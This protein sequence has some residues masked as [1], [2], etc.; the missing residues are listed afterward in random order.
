MEKII[1]K[2]TAK[3]IVLKGKPEDGHADVFSYNYEGSA[4]SN[5]GSLFVVG[6]VYPA[7]EDTSYMI[8]LVASLAKREYYSQDNSAHKEA[9]SRT[10][11][12]IN[13]VLQ[14]FFRN[15]D[16]S[17]NIG[18]FAIA[19]DNILI[20]RLGKFKI[21][22]GRD[23]QNIDIL[24]NVSLFEKEHI[25]EKEFSNVISGKIMPK[26]KILAF[27]ASRAMTS[28]E[29]TIKDLLPKLK[30]D[31]FAEK[32][33][34]IK[35]VNESFGCTAIHITIDK[36][37]ESAIVQPPQPKELR[38]TESLIKPVLTKATATSPTT[39]QPDLTPTNPEPI[40][41]VGNNNVSKPETTNQKRIYYP[42]NNDLL[43]QSED[44]SAELPSLIRPS[45]FLSAS[46]GNIFTQIFGIFSKFKLN[47]SM[48]KID[49][50]Q[51]RP[52]LKKKH[53]LTVSIII[54]I[55]VV[56]IVAKVTF[57][58]SLPIPGFGSTQ[59][60]ALKALI[61]D[62]EM[63]LQ[64][65]I[66][67]KEQDQLEARRMLFEALSSLP[68]SND[69]PEKVINLQNEILAVLD[70]I[71]KASE[72]SPT[73]FQQVPVNMG[74][75]AL[76]TAWQNKVFVY[77]TGQDSANNIIEVDGNGTNRVI[78]LS[79]FVPRYLTAT[80]N[81]IIM[82]T[83]TNNIFGYISLDNNNLK[84]FPLDTLGTAK[85]FYLYQDNLY[86]LGSDGIYKIVDAA[87]GKNT[88]TPW[89][90]AGVQVPA[91]SN[92][93]TVNSNIYV[94]TESGNL[95]TYYKGDKTGE[96]SISVPAEQNTLLL[97][98]TDSPLI[99]M[100]NKNLN[101]IYTINKT[102]GSLEKT[103]KLTGSPFIVSG[104]ISTDGK[105]L[106]LLSQDNKIWQIPL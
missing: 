27:Y 60:K 55:V 42:E 80:E 74:K 44:K 49:S 86:I 51:N 92:S 69:N 43:N 100:I 96:T 64:K 87:K 101:R 39:T 10:L 77:T 85:S 1:I 103:I 63:K 45:E 52:M 30:A 89:L 73:L 99:Y 53:F 12:K 13:E 102:S 83:Q 47:R 8:N 9:F 24:N 70:E 16:L 93:I 54:L 98:T 37:K 19:G 76:I 105:T 4:I 2:P 21:I 25:Q 61:S 72:V 34:A 68:N 79:D 62:N 97:A 67:V 26:D 48:Y 81:S 29:K 15:K 36:F 33:A 58:P 94:I 20:S 56:G 18:I 84:T 40:K 90:N 7:S 66:S 17:A 75:V 11:K 14:D 88:V 78:S 35:Q 57:A 3:E 22:L 38:K 31:E 82:V 59:N 71:D 41:D 6:Q 5:L 28:R 23:N 32:I 95:L 104:A 50:G 91:N 65:A 46:K 106:Y